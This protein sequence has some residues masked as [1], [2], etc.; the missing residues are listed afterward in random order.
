MK[1][2]IKY[3]ENNASGEGTSFTGSQEKSA[4]MESKGQ[5]HGRFIS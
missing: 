4:V 5:E 1:L 2:C 3:K